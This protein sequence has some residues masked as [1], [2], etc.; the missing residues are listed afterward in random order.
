MLGRA[1]VAPMRP[2]LMAL[3]VVVL[4]QVSPAVAQYV[5]NICGWNSGTCGV[6]PSPVGSS[7]GCVTNFGIMQ[8]QILQPG[9]GY[10]M[11][12][13]MAVSNICR[14]GRGACQTYPLPLGSQCNCFG[15]P[16]LVS[17]R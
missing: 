17:P 11:A 3:A 14:T 9:G 2:T 13:Q 12:P 1:F 8:G 5:N 7:C 15:D 10:Q 6:N 16:G 4:F